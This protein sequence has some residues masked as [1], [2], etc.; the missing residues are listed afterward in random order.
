MIGV[1]IIIC[2]GK[3]S[4]LLNLKFTPGDLWALGGSIGWAFYSVYL[5][6]WKSKLGIFPRFTLISLF[7]FISILP[8]YLAEE[9][10]IQPTSF[11]ENFFIW[12]I[13]AAILPGI[14]SFSLYT[15][16][17]KYLGASTTGFTLYL[18]TVYGAFYGIVFFGE[19][20]EI[21]HYFGT[22]LVFF[23]IYLVK[24]RTHL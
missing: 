6:N 10:F 3:L 16:T 20:L 7:G 2:N 5:Y 11:D 23:G 24:K 18:F 4:L 1:L 17:Q 8:F 22:I 9:V 19:H 14:I 15:M 12:I 21:Y 13:F